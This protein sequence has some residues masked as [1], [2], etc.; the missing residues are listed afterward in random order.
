MNAAVTPVFAF[1]FNAE[2]LARP[3]EGDGPPEGGFR[4]LHLDRH[5]AALVDWLA[6]KVPPVVAHA[7]VQAETRPRCDIHEGGLMLNLRGVNLNPGEDEEDMVSLR[8]WARADL[9]LTVRLRRL[10]AVAAVREAVEAEQPFVGPGA[11]LAAVTAGLT[12]RIEAVSLALEDEADALE[13]TM[14]DAPD[15]LGARLAP[16]RQKAIKLGRYLRPQREA[17]ARLCVA[18]VDFL[19]G[20]DRVHLRE[21]AN[22]LTRSVEELEATRDRLAAVQDH[23][24]VQTGQKLGR[25]GY[26]LSVVAAVFLPL[27]F[28]TGLFGVNVGGMPG[29]GSANAFAVLTAA[30]AVL[31]VVLVAVLRW[32]KWM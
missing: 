23:L 13:E 10:K 5:D 20:P 17:L 31:G 16:L 19:S 12:D 28:L 18:E 25:N 4:W 1:D 21:T 7:L 9:L 6:N 8:V 29:V 15:G 24:D 22:M 3:S 14:F 27:G 30:M 11:V 2:G 26:L 32:M